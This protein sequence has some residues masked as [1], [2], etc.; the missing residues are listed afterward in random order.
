MHGMTIDGP[1]LPALS[2]TTRQLVILVHGYGS[3]GQDLISLAPMWR[4]G[5]PDAAFVAPNAPM[6]LPG[7][8]YQWWPLGGF[9]ANE[10]E[11][12]VVAAAPALDAF[13]DAELAR[14]GLG[15]E[16]LLLVGFSQGTMLSLHVAP[17]RA[18]PV[19]GVIGYSGMLIAPERLDTEL[20]SKP[21]VLLVHGSADEIV[22]A[23]ALPL[24]EQAL[25]DR[26][27]TVESHVSPG[28]GHGID[29][30]GLAKGI[31]FAKRVLNVGG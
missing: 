22:P 17:R 25:T 6:R 27:F 15:E 9:S 14:T 4:A 5:L 1:R 12:G 28:L 16:D 7:A 24:A 31:D 3:D 23:R 8:G 13:I 21:P 26:G 11:V 18:K 10:R 30:P 2:G 20:K 29:Q 19:A